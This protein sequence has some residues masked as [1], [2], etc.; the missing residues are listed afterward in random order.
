MTHENESEVLSES[1]S[2]AYSYLNAIDPER[3]LGCVGKAEKDP[4]N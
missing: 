4:S 3:S 2:M 1:E